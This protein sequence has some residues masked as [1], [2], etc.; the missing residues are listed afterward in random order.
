[1]TRQRDPAGDGHSG[2]PSPALQT[3]KLH[4]ARLRPDTVR[5]ARLTSLLVA[6]R[7]ALALLVAP[8]GF[9]K[10][11]LLADWS[12]NDLRQAAHVAAR[13]VETLENRPPRTRR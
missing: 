11:S 5:R 4:S 7:P 12:E 6:E 8:A 2:R 13:L 3:I 10:T 1:M 9:G